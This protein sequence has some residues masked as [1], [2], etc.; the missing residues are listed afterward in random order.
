MEYT[1][2]TSDEFAEL[3]GVDD[4]RF[5]L[6]AIHAAF[7]A[8][9]YPAAADLAVAIT[10]VAERQ[11]H[12]PDIDIRYPGT[13]HVTLTTHAVGGLTTLDVDLAREISALASAAGIGT[14]ERSI[15]V[16]E[17][18]IDTM[19]AAKIRPFWAAVLDYTVVDD[20]GS[21]VD[22][23]RQ[24]W[25]IWFQQMDE[26]RTDRNRF[27]LDVSVPH[28]VAEQRIAAALAAGGRMVSDARAKAFWILADADGN[29]A[30]IC[31]WQDR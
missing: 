21:L 14:A 4:W 18:C 31:T 5:A 13:V 28:D 26:P 17:L 3:T 30:C 7:A 24:G 6:G 23:R 25:P 15:Q 9:S 20:D 29:E 8:G 2:V 12:H 10:E 27:H 16:T 19:D 22:P 11:V 1:S